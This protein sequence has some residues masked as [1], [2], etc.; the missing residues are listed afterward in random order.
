MTKEQQ[1]ARIVFMLSGLLIGTV[2]G[3]IIVVLTI[4]FHA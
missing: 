4:V 3:V 1:D 2:L